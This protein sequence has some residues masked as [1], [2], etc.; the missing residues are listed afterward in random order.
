MGLDF[1]LVRLSLAVSGCQTL[2]LEL[3]GLAFY[4]LGRNAF[5][6]YGCFFRLYGVGFAFA[7]FAAMSMRCLDAENLDVGL[8]CGM[9][10]C[11]SSRHY[12]L[13]P[14]TASPT[15]LKVQYAARRQVTCQAP[16]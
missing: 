7:C 12:V 10:G 16:S 2:S 13:K 11:F 5:W 15:P 1:Q 9:N 6:L 3:W 4:G 14:L 8:G